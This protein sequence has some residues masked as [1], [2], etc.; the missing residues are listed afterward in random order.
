MCT[1]SADW[2]NTQPLADV[3]FRCPGRHRDPARSQRGRDAG[4]LAADPSERDRQ[5]RAA[6]RYPRS[7]RC[8]IHHTDGIPK[9]YGFVARIRHSW[10]S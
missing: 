4:G 6:D 5:R 2:A 1:A 8:V 7:V 3:R 10:A 9:P